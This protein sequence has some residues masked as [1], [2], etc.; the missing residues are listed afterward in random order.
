MRGNRRALN[1]RD[2]KER[3]QQESMRLRSRRAGDLRKGMA[4]DEEIS[5]D[6][7]D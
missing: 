1:R 3:E 7:L 2:G 5:M 6:V 4:T